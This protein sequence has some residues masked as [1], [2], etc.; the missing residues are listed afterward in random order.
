VFK[1][2][3]RIELNQMEGVTIIGDELVLKLENRRSLPFFFSSSDGAIAARGP[4]E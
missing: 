4:L 2:E 1:I 3:G